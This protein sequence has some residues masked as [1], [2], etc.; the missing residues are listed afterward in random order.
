MVPKSSNECIIVGAFASD[1]I[2]YTFVGYVT[3]GVVDIN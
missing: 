2:A 1:T 3:F